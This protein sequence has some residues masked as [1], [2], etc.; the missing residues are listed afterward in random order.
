MVYKNAN[1][2]DT[3]KLMFSHYNYYL[4]PSTY[5]SKHCIRYVPIHMDNVHIDKSDE[6][7]SGFEVDENDIEWNNSA[8]FDLLSETICFP[9]YCDIDLISLLI[10]RMDELG[11]K[12]LL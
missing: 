10:K 1:P 9:G 2:T 11:F 4:H 7:P 5:H 3:E 6:F 12:R 8:E